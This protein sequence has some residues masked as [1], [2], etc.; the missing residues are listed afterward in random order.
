MFGKSQMRSAFV[1]QAL[2]L[3][4]APRPSEMTGTCFLCSA[5]A[6]PH[7]FVTMMMFLY[8]DNH[9]DLRK[10]MTFKWPVVV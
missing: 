4:A 3:W 5:A 10:A 9:N 2:L 6:D 7:S 1:L 8:G